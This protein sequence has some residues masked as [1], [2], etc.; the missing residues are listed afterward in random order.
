MLLAGPGAA[1]HAQEQINDE[2]QTTKV[3]IVSLAA[4]LAHIASRLAGA[5]AHNGS[6][7]GHIRHRRPHPAAAVPQ[8]QEAAVQN[9]NKGLVQSVP[10]EFKG[11]NLTVVALSHE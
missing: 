8:T 5:A 3:A 6:L 10:V 7:G 9:I 4:E 1:V 2:Q 11:H